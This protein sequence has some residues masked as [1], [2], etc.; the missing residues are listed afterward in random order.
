[1]P[2]TP[3]A[4]QPKEEYTRRLGA[5]QGALTVCERSHIRLGN[6][7]L[8]VVLVFA[9][10]VVIVFTRA[11]L[12]AWWLLA[13][14]AAF[15]WLGGRL[16]RRLNERRRLSRAVAWCQRALERLDGRW[17]GRG[18]PGTRFLDDH[19][20]YAADLDIFGDASLF[21]L[22]CGART[23]LGE[24]TL[25]SWLRSAAAPETVRVRQ[26]AVSELAPLVDLREDLAV[27]GEDARAGVQAEPLA[28]WGERPPL[29]PFGWRRALAGLLSSVGATALAAL[30]VSLSAR[31]GLI[32]LDELTLAGLQAYFLASM[33]LMA[34]LGWRVHGRTS[35]IFR[36]AAAAAVDLGLLSGVLQR[37]EAERFTSPRLAALRA[38]LQVEGAPPSRRIA[39][40]ARLMH[41]VEAREHILVRL[42][43][44]AVLL[45]LHF[46]YALE[47]WRRR[48]GPAMRRWLNAVGEIEALSSLAGFAYER[49]LN[50]FPELAVGAPGF[51][52]EGV[53]HPLLPQQAAVPN[54][55][56][57]GGEVQLIVVSGSNMS[58]KSTLLRTLGVNTVLAQAGA[59]VCA[60]RLQLSPLAVGASIRIQDSL[61]EGT[62]RF[63]A[64][65]TRL[66]QIM[67]L[68]G[69]TP[70][71][72]LVDEFLHGTNSHDRRI[73][74]EAIVRG[75]VDRDAIGLVTTHD[76]ALAQIADALGPRAANAHFEDTLEDGRLHFDYRLQP[77]VVRKSNAIELMRSVGLD[78]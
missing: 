17:A 23:R 2:D 3:G 74:A 9:V 78:V 35:R 53:F 62:S 31:D 63:Y 49:P 64:E 58:G 15:F 28:A 71:L 47:G 18:E 56:R 70:V 36:E 21:Q 13:P 4:G 41:L 51:A 14:A 24:E 65:I 30:F 8:L 37:L 7:R 46:A 61:H 40:L 11:A 5:R 12:P 67:E 32:Q 39:Q 44:P 76:L 29:L 19:H 25:A 69:G 55:V 26:T 6:V 68:A 20:L 57:L 50:V 72:F 42:F 10:M 22:L 1:L 75:L 34:F 33:I 27:L 43:G 52:A 54:D 38:E 48:S 77:G 60:R 16:E 45:D 66:R 73:G 59:P